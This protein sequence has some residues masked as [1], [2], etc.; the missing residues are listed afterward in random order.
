[1]FVNLSFHLFVV[2]L[3]L[4]S[5]C[6]SFYSMI[7]HMRV[8]QEINIPV[9][10]H[11]DERTFKWRVS[12][13]NSVNGDCYKQVDKLKCFHILLIYRNKDIGCKLFFRSYSKIIII[14]IIM[15]L[16]HANNCPLA[17]YKIIIETGNVNAKLR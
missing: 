16:K 12:S 11:Q 8:R 17:L 13:V 7:V 9:G 3:P 14:I 1:M 5:S 6:V 4:F 2:F 15:N 10:H